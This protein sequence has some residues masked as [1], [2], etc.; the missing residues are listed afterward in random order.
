MSFDPV[1]YLATKGLHGKPVSGGR[2]VVYPCWSDCNEPADSSKR[3]LYVNAETGL[4]QCKV[5]TT[6]GGPFTMQK[7]FGDEP[8]AGTTDDVFMRQRILDAATDIGI[9]MLMQADDVCLYLLNDRGLH[10]QTLIDRKL[11][12]VTAGWS[13]VGS[14][15]QD[16][17]KEQIKSTGLVHRDGDRAG[18]DFFWRHILIPIQRHGHTVQIRGRA[19]GESRGGK[20]MTGPGEPVRAFNVDSL[21]G[22]EEVIITEGEFDA[23]ILAQT[24]A[25]AGTERARKM[26]VI[27]LPGTNALP[28]DLLDLLYGMKW[29]YVAFDSDEAGTAAAQTLKDKI[30]PRTRIVTLPHNGTQK[31]DWTEYLLPAEPAFPSAIS[32]QSWQREHPYAGHDWRDVMKLLSSAAGKRIFSIAEAGDAWRAFR[33]DHSG[34]VTGFAQL[35]A[36]IKPGLLPGQVVIVLA[37][38][39]AGKTIFLCNLAYNMRGQRVLFITLEN[40]R[41]EIYERMRRIYLFHHPFSNDDQVETGLGN[42]FV[43]DENRIAER[44]LAALVAEYELETGE[45]PDVV[46]VD[47]LGYFA[48]GAR[49]NSPYEKVGNAVMTLKAEA[50]GGRYVVISPAQVNRG[51]KEGRPIDLDDA[52]DAGSVEETADFLMSLYRPDDGLSAEGLI[53][54]QPPSGKVKATLLKSRHGNKGLDFPMRMDL[55]TLAIVDDNTPAAKLVQENNYLAHRGYDWDDLRRRQLAPVQQRFEGMST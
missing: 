40:T 2:E 7:A 37:K 18:K 47:Y 31:C 29:V 15:P 43:C 45:R 44:D 17:T 20:Y 10:E 14:L 8:R 3:K 35:D 21:E 53:N 52:R 4:W 22:A 50:K 49:G 33:Q 41:E 19:W 1:A 34:L 5:C 54:E 38:T 48:R 39:G 55:L 13:L 26:A 28:D 9:Q 24:L 32:S 11:G 36:A 6:E 51:A 30:G 16:V 23:M 12:F 46:F 42:V 27:G 25:G